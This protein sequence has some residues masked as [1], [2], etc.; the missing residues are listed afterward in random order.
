MVLFVFQFFLVY[1]FGLVT[2]R[3][4]WVKKGSREMRFCRYNPPMRTSLSRSIGDEK[5][6]EVQEDN[7]EPVWNQVSTCNLARRAVFALR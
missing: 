1:I 5:K 6:T 7:L 3:S 4:E 2:V